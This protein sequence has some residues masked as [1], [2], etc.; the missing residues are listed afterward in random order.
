MKKILAVILTVLLCSCSSASSSVVPSSEAED[1]VTI[2]VI[3][4]LTHGSLDE[5]YQGFLDGLKEAGYEEGK[6]LEII[7]QNPE[8]DQSNLA[9]M[10]DAVVAK[11]PDLIVAIATPPAQAVQQALDSAGKSIP[12][13]GTAITSYTETGLAETDEKPGLGISGVSDNCPMDL[14]LMLA[15]Q[16][17]P[18]LKTLGILYTSSEANSQIQAEQMEEVCVAAGVQ[19]LVKTVSDKTMIDDTMQSF[20][21]NVD[22]LYIP[23]DNN[24]ASAM[25]SVD[26]VAT[27]NKLPV[28][29]GVSA[30]CADGGLVALGVDYYV[31]GKVTAE[32]A[33]E[34]LNGADVSEMPIRYGSSGTIYYNPRTAENLGITL[35]DNILTDGIDVTAE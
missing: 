19:T 18:E 15:Q 6:N 35:P 11:D 27:E 3:Q 5:D 34:V 20:T 17:V 26:I 24:I 1:K 31:L 13:L 28:V 33:V 25:G 30:M 12:V 29:V 14:Q 7:Y 32:M 9:T 16:I 23:T 4:L 8:G 10:A 22:A 21:G 2:A